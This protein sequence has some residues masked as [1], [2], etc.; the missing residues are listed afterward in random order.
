MNQWRS[1]M[2]VS[3]RKLYFDLLVTSIVHSRPELM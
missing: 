1:K 3:H 2:A